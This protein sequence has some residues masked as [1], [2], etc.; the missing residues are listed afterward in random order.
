ML[1]EAVQQQSV[2]VSARAP[3]ARLVP[4]AVQGEQYLHGSTQPSTLSTAL[5]P[6]HPQPT[7]LFPT[8]LQVSSA[9]SPAA[10]LSEAGP[11]TTL[12]HFISNRLVEVGCTT[13]FSVPGDYNLVLLDNMLLNKELKVRQCCWAYE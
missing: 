5:P 7:T 10:L 11:P 1:Y 12:G 9:P 13:A 6:N 2:A 4:P 8:T 3:V